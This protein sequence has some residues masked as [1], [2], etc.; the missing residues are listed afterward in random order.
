MKKLLHFFN[1][2]LDVLFFDPEDWFEPVPA[3]ALQ[4]A[5]DSAVADTLENVEAL[6]KWRTIK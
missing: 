4:V 1:V 5:N 6:Q 2:M 3:G